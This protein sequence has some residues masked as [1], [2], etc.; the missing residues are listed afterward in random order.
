MYIYLY[1]KDPAISTTN[2]YSPYENGLENGVFIKSV[3][4]DQPLVGKVWPGETVYPDFTN[5]NTTKWWTR[6]ASDFHSKIPFDGL[7]IV[8]FVNLKIN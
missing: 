6:L 5:P 7:W 8:S 4:S 3:D 1:V 2:G